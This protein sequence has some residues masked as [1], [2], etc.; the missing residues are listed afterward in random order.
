MKDNIK[1]IVISTTSFAEYDN[2][3][4]ELCKKRGYE[5]FFNPHKR[6]VKPE[7]LID[8]SR[9]AIGLIAGTEA[10]SESVLTKL[11]HIKVISRCGSGIDNIDLDATKSLGIKVFNTPDAPTLAVAE[12][13]VGLMLNLLRKTCQMNS[14]TKNGIWQKRMGSLLY[15]KR[16]GIKGFGRIGRKVAEL[17]KPF[18]CEIAYADPNVK[19]GLLGF[20]CLSLEDLLAWADI[21]TIHV[22][23]GKKL[24]GEKEFKLLKKGT[25]LINTSRGGAVDESILYEYLR[26]GYLTGAAVDVFEDEPYI[27]P[28]KKLDNIIL[29]PHIGSYAKEA[30]I[31][32]EKQAMENLLKGLKGINNE[33]TKARRKDSEGFVSAP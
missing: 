2:L 32:M 11:P 15:E 17:L 12:L 14:D 9:D 22:G 19:D 7:E 30:R 31:E 21:V 3:P 25:W 20:K 33:D 29:T 6:K 16:V 13:T 24:I 8:L 26:S 5:V 4:V 28:L 27:G 23:V 1:K 10:I 18:N